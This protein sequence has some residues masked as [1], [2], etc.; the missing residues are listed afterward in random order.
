MIQTLATTT[1]HTL[2]VAQF[3][4]ELNQRGHHLRIAI[5]SGHASA[6]MSAAWLIIAGHEMIAANEALGERRGRT[7]PGDAPRATFADWLATYAVK[8]DGSPVSETWAR[9]L[10]ACAKKHKEEVLD[11]RDK[12][13]LALLAV[14]PS[15][16]DDA[17]RS[18]FL[19][20]TAEFAGDEGI[21]SLMAE[22]NIR[23]KSKKG[24][25]TVSAART[26][27]DVMP[28]GF[29]PELWAEYQQLEDGSPAKQAV[30][31]VRAMY[32]WLLPMASTS[33]D[34]ASPHIP[35]LPPM[36]AA[37]LYDLLQQ[38]SKR[39][40]PL[41]K[42]AKPAKKTDAKKTGKKNARK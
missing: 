20:S 21:C 22:L 16:M 27:A 30:E 6:A 28:P 8:P 7:K 33:P 18:K 10:M 41:V 14:A 26:N 19:E 12:E 1:E 35:H 29:T 17:Q 15:E 13:T 2:T 36:F 5:A 4:D 3:D 37:P 32:G 11:T 42:S 39:L 34:V 24:T 40:E 25:G 23:R 38:A 31:S 9:Q